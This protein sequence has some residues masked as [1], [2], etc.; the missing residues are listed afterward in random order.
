MT[1]LNHSITGAV[2]GKLLPLP[3]AIPLAFASHFVLDAIP[4]FGE[5]FDKRKKLSKTIWTIDI[6]ASLC[7]LLFLLFMQQWT[8][9]VCGLVAM[10]P[11]I[12]WIYRFTIPEKFGK[13]P[14]RPENRFNSW[15][16]RIQHESRKGLAV[17]IIWLIAMTLLLAKVW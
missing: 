1:G 5:V 2:I 14:P 8:M 15:H 4:H 10:S 9:L 17:E 7:F 13:V 3:I 6:S 12:A 11:D 16:V